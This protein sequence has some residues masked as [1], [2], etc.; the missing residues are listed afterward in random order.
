MKHP[1]ITLAVIL[2]LLCF[3][4]FIQNTEVVTLR[5]LFWKLPVSQI[6]LI[7]FL[8]LTGFVLGYVVA[9]LGKKR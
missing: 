6:I 5:F 8:M 7:P 2:A 3:V 9:T 4:I 1:K